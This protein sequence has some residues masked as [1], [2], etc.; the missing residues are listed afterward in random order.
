MRAD[1]AAEAGGSTLRFLTCG[2]VD[3]GKSTLIGRLLHESG[4]VAE[5]QME[6]L[7]RDSARFGTNGAA[8]DFALLVDGLEDERSQGITIDVA[9]RYFATARRRFIVADTPGHAQ[10]TRNMAT[11][12]AA[13]EL[14]VL[15]VDARA[16]LLAQ[17]R[18]HAF[19]AAL[20]GIRH[21][22]LAVNKMDLVAFDAA[23]FE[24]I[25]AAF[26]DAA[27]ALGFADVTAIPLVARD[28]DNLARPSGRMAWY[29]GP[30]LLGHLETVDVAP[31][32][33]ADF[34]L[35]VQWVNR[36]DAEFR[37]YAG[38]I[39]AGSVRPGD[40]L[41]VARSGLAAR[42]ARIVTHGGDLPAA[43][44]GVAVTLTLDAPLDVARGDVLAAGRP[45]P[46]S[47]R[48]EADL[49][50]LAEAK[51]FQGRDYLVKLGTA[52]LPG[53]V[54]RIHHRI[55]IDSFEQV[56]AD[57]LGLND[58]ASVT[59]A[60]GVPA[61]L[62]RFADSRDLGGFVLIDRMSNATVAVGMVREVAALAG[63][64]VW[65]RQSVDRAARAALK[66]QH[67]AAL[68]FTGLSG[69]GKSTI[70]NIVEQQLHALG[71]HTVML[72]GDNVRHGLNRDLGFSE[73]DRVENIRRAAEVARLM[74]EAGLIVLVSFISPYRSDRAAARARFEAGDFIEGFVDTDV[75]ECR[76]RDPKGLYKRADAGE[77]RNFTGVSAPYEA[78]DAPELWLR[79][80]T[81]TA[82][83]LAGE[84]VAF[85]RAHGVVP[86]AP[87]GR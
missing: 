13:A 58:L 45:V 40:L 74:V 32:G 8:P 78:P 30:T 2:S 87:G 5:D 16:G 85:L 68:W 6:R 51:L 25:V 65:Q 61:A 47:D 53:S 86:G 56:P 29:R 79:T 84:V 70:A 69:A 64:V 66:G 28:G 75:E 22:V 37:G 36:A 4:A 82:E 17:T 33:G 76:R 12:A 43:A 27:R 14:A 57:T 1:Q 80:E 9:Y 83:T 59:V 41:T 21:V 20:M 34:R 81:G 54:T 42:V 26:A 38:T 72:D 71:H 62:E 10:Y 49:I 15:L 31:G 24:A 52:T 35:P 50:W 48:F 60:L 7:T 11:G 77:L 44:Q 18:R 23:R 3:D 46:I 73:A 67:P 39:A 63:G 19:I 55:D